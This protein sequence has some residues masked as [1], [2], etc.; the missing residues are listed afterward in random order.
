[1]AAFCRSKSI[2]NPDSRLTTSPLRNNIP[3]GANRTFPISQWA[4][5]A[6]Y[7]FT[8]AFAVQVGAYDKNPGNAEASNGFKPFI[9]GSQGTSFPIEAIWKGQVAGLNAEYH[10]GYYYA[11]ADTKD[12]LKD[13][14]GNVGAS[15]QKLY[16]MYSSND[17]W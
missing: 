7:Q 12:M 6:K 13:A 14:D 17:G 4:V 1:M 10:V 5:R 16:R 2:N 3:N 8:D 15:S 9:S 11:N